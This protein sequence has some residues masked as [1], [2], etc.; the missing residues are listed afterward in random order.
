MSPK[1]GSKN[2]ALALLIEVISVSSPAYLVPSISNPAE[3]PRALLH[4]PT[5]NPTKRV[6]LL[7][8]FTNNLHAPEKYFYILTV[9][10]V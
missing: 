8:A 6:L 5:K 2:L 10:D 3:P 4:E 7:F 1:I 9:V